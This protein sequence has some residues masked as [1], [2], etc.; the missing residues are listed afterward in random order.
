MKKRGLLISFAALICS[1]LIAGAGTPVYASDGL[2]VDQ[3][4]PEEIRKHIDESDSYLGVHEE[5]V[6]EPEMNTV[7]GELTEE[8]QK[9][10]LGTLNDIRYIAGLDPVELDEEYCHYAQAAAFVNMSL[11]T[12]THYPA[13]TADKPDEMS[14]DD[15][16]DGCIGAR[17][18]NLA[19]GYGHLS[20]ATLGWSED[21]DSSN[22]ARVGHRR[23]MLNPEMGRTGFGA[24]DDCYAMYAFDTSAA[25]GQYN[26]AWPAANM[27]IE[28]FYSSIPWSLSTGD[29]LNKSDIKVTLTR[30]RDGK[31]WTFDGSKS[32]SVYADEYFNVDNDCFG[33]TG[34]IIFRPKDTGGYKAG[35]QYR[36]EIT[37]AGDD[38]IVYTVNF[39]ELTHDIRYH[40]ANEPTTKEEGNIEYWYCEGC[41]KYYSDSEGK[42]EIKREDTIIPKLPIK[43]VDSGT[44]G[45]N[46]KWTLDNGGTLT[47]SGTG[48]IP[49]YVPYYEGGNNV[50]PFAN[51]YDVYDIIIEDGITRIGDAAFCDVQYV[52]T[53]TIP[54]SVTSIGDNAFQYDWPSEIFFGGTLEEW[55]AIT[56]G[57][58]NHMDYPAIRTDEEHVWDSDYTIDKEPTC[59]EPGSMSVH[60]VDCGVIWRSTIREIEA[61]GHDYGEWVTTAEP[62]C[63]QPG[64]RESMC[65]RCGEKVVE[66]IAATG[67]S[68]G[69]WE[70]VNASDCENQGLRQRTCESCGYV[71]SENLDPLGHDWEEEATVD[72]EPLCDFDGS[73]SVH[74]TRCKATKDVEVIPALGHE[75]G[76]WV[77]VEEP[78]CSSTGWQEATC[79]RCGATVGQEI[80]CLEH[81]WSDEPEIATPATCKAEG[82][83]VYT[84]TVCGAEKEEPI[85]KLA[86]HK[87]GAWKVSKAATELAAGQKTRTCTVCG[88]AEKATIAMLKPSLPAPTIKAPKA[89]KKSA[90]VKWKKLSKANQKKIGYI[91]IQYSTDKKFKTGVK[92]VTA[93]KS[94]ASKKITKLTSKKVYYVRIRSYLKSG[95]KVHIS[96]WSTV[97]SVKAK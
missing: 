23:W 60:C 70:Q 74:C 73:K 15:W 56:I 45:S 3:H 91:Q 58:N 84:C 97:K 39:F 47:L 49:D 26:V 31:V 66:E 42:N 11:R 29:H 93:K 20:L 65:S 7:M 55:N 75:T 27:P 78:T 64:S 44:C 24:A 72:L 86:S 34:C 52:E 5:F 1:V 32:Y 61:L 48:P 8:S 90:T 38:D 95:G 46:I 62:T 92:T 54:A 17:A 68:F 37:G 21:D 82:I 67:H 41:D 22:I 30:L 57:E 36:V 51:N 76:E 10:G 50:S 80:P 28:Y 88:H 40:S 25:G 96:K 2:H 59:T 12:I 16:T 69:E 63:T 19:M 6:T 71:E 89:A 77:T 9:N 13:D 79:S 33:Q 14:E 94:A 35:D 87:F 85:P 83:R 18:S 53:V 81:E 43:V 4:S